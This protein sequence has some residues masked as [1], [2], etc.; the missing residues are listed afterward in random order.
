MHSQFKSMPKIFLLYIDFF[1]FLQR[2]GIQS[3]KHK[4][5]KS[6]AIL[7][8]IIV[9][10]V[11]CHIHRLGFRI[12][13]MSLPE[14]SVFEHYNYCREKK[15]YH[16]PVALYLMAISHYFF[17]VFS[18]SINFI[19]YCAMGRQFQLQLKLLCKR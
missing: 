2:T 14:G 12:Y 9:V 5:E 3:I 10:F 6:T 16:I 7:I 8:A 11:A 18:S 4:Q 13:E 19:I 15:K 1:H 17:I